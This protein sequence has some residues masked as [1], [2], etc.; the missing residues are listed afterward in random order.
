MAGF[1]SKIVLSGF[2]ASLLIGCGGD[3]SSTIDSSEN[4]DPVSS[5]NDLADV[6]DI[7]NAAEVTT[8]D[9]QIDETAAPADNTPQAAT[10]TCTFTSEDQEMLRLV[11]EARAEPRACGNQSFA[12]VD[13][14]TLNC[15][16]KESSERHSIAMA[17][18]N[19]FDHEGMD[20]STEGSRVTDA[21]Y[22]WRA[23]GENIAAGQPTVA[24]VMQG[25]LDSPGHCSNIMSP[26]FTEFGSASQTS[27]SSDFSIYWTQN[28]AR[29]L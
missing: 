23:V 6:T 18:L 5:A 9:T 13:P 11:N 19:F 22:S 10:G 17:D 12:Q 25:W 29:P 8:V 24:E 21:G 28:F 7:T 27:S 15:L 16:L 14:L 2:I 3:G 20:G 1:R 26:A 4:L